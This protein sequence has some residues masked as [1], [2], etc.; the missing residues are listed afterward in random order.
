[1]DP[2][3]NRV[4]SYIYTIRLLKITMVFFLYSII[5]IVLI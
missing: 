3:S 5:I 4:C 2:L 1:M